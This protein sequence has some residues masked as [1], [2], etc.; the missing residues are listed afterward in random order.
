VNFSPTLPP[1][2]PRLYPPSTLRIGHKVLSL[3]ALPQRL[4][5]GLPHADGDIRA[6]E[7]GRES[8]REG[9]RE[10]GEGSEAAGQGIPESYQVILLS[11]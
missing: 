8:G 2:L 5:K 1:S 10:E 7:G 4:H 11:A 3:L 9:G 6:W